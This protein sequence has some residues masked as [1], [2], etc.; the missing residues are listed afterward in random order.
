MAD[1]LFEVERSI[2]RCRLVLSAVALVAVVADPTEPLFGKWTPFGDRG[3]ALDAY[4][5]A[6]LLTYGCYSIAAYAALV[7]RR[8]SAER[9]ADVTTWGDVLFGA[10]IAFFTEGT[11]SPFDMFFVFA[12]VVV[13][14]RAGLRRT[15]VVTAVSVLLHMSLIAASA[16]GTMNYFLMR[17]VHLAIIGYLV[18]SVGQERLNLE[19][20]MRELVA[21]SQRARIASELH[22]GWAQSLAGINL[23]LESCRELL[24]RGRA[25]DVLGALTDL[26][27]SVTHEYDAFR[28]YMRS[29]AGVDRSEP[30]RSA[31]GGTRFAV[32]LEFDASGPVVDQVLQ[33]AREGVTNVLRHS[34]AEN[35]SIAVW[36]EGDEL[37][38]RIDDDGVGFAVPG[39]RPWSITT[40]VEDLG[41]SIR[42]EDSRPG[43]HVSIALPVA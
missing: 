41:G 39:Q 22:D 3:P 1:R 32:R 29:L 31:T 17:P 7:G 16:P 27:R 28:G 43:A 18:G 42:T 11:A 5:L 38:I 21:A 33:I 4:T 26:Q 25:A 36:T 15:L 2:A 34:R 24:R 23:E 20:E 13:S 10:A 9:L 40:R 30:S 8:V 19:R 6:V 14:F 37:A 35:A 12:V